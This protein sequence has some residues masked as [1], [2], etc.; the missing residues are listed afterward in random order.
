[1]GQLGKSSASYQQQSGNQ[2]SSSRAYFDDRGNALIK[3]L[4][5][6]TKQD[7]PYETTAGNYFTGEVQKPVHSFNPSTTVASYDAALN[8]ALAA[9]RSFTRN[10]PDTFGE[11]TAARVTAQNRADLA[12]DLT[13]Q[14]E[15]V[16]QF[17]TNRQAASAGALAGLGGQQQAQDASTILG[18][19]SLL[20][21]ED[22]TQKQ[23]QKGF[24]LVTG[25]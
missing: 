17:E 23:K 5:D 14:E 15:A 11:A 18:L 4:T 2:S 16:R 7:N 10:R 21:G 13:Q 24:S 8:P 9:A 1:M 19:L 20:R 6:Q 3:Y 25:P 12:R 22:T